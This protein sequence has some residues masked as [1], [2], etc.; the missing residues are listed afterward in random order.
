MSDSPSSVHRPQAV[1]TTEVLSHLA[2]SPN[3]YGYFMAVGNPN[4][5]PERAYNSA[6]ANIDTLKQYGLLCET[7]K[8]DGH[9]LTEF[10]KTVWDACTKL[11][12][13]AIMIDEWED[14]FRLLPS[15][16]ETILSRP[17]LQTAECFTGSAFIGNQGADE[18]LRRVHQEGVLLIGPQPAHRKIL[19][20]EDAD[21]DILLTDAS[22]SKGTPE[23]WTPSS[24][25]PQWFRYAPSN[26]VSE[27]VER[28][29]T[30]EAK[31]SV[32][33]TDTALLMYVHDTADPYRSV[34]IEIPASSVSD[35]IEEIL[36]LRM[37]ASRIN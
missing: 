24:S 1:L 28:T 14:L 17:L 37:S 19:A 32:A 11:T 16:D 33:I 29:I 20:K 27:E 25:P 23:E 9:R 12:D 36:S 26:Q 3:T 10:G 6:E 5:D 2:G 7:S 35:L 18:L 21:V 34:L 8:A 4:L 31:T 30:S 22:I 13:A 15:W